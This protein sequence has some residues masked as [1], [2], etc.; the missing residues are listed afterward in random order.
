MSSNKP[1][2]V[3][4]R[5]PVTDYGNLTA[6]RYEFLG[7]NQAEPN[8]GPGLA[9]SILALGNNN[10]RIWTNTVSLL[11]L[12]A[13]GNISAGNVLVGNIVVFGTGNITG[14]DSI[15]ASGNITGGNI[16]V[17][18]N[19]TAANFIGNISGNI[20]AA[21]DNTQVQFND[22]GDLL[23][24]SA[25]FTFDKSSNVLTVLGNIQ[26]GNIL[27]AGVISSTSTITGGNILTAGLIS[28]AGTVV[29]SNLITSGY[30]SITGNGTYAHGNN[31]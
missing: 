17:S 5:V 10:T 14:V 24:A 2:L 20:D 13:T 16:S 15:S 25:A 23:G 31:C 30:A 28:A 9:N 22:T 6:D 4:G 21:G 26:G 27:T 3:S 11:S 19:V 12:D 1:F 7:L 29:G 8:L 18:G